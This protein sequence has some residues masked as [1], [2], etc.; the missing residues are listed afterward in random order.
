MDA[1]NHPDPLQDAMQEG[2]RHA[3]EVAYA[4]GTGA[5][6]Y[7]Q[8]KRA[9]AQVAAE[10]DQR[11]RR[12]LNAQIRAARDAARAG[13]AAA[14][15]PA[16]L[17][18]AGLLQTAR[19]WGAAMPYADRAVPWYEPAAAAAVRKCE[20][21]LRVLHPYAMARYDR[22]RGDGMTPAE[23]MREAAPLFTR[24]PQAREG[25]YTPRPAL[26]NDAGAEPTQAWAG[27]PGPGG[28]TGL[29][30]A[31]Q[32]RAATAESIRA[33][34]LNAAADLESTPAVDERTSNLTAARGEAAAASAAV[35]RAA[36]ALRPWERDF[37]VP[38]HEVVSLRAAHPISAPLAAASRAP[39]RR[40]VL[41]LR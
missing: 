35:A 20:D 39:V 18:H 14:L 10:H 5:Q 34:D 27:E 12:A 31:E 13:W 28:T 36:R 8:H 11:A 41:L 38:I 40:P 7:L 32:D 25:F 17:H 4:L 23:A 29:M 6:I 24:P 15:D 22:L 37:P 21:R 19:V 1:E 30:R 2:L 3:V 16:W 9:Q 26:S 33:A